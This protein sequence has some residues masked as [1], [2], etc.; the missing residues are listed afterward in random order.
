M[1]F[2]KYKFE[3]IRNAA[4]LTVIAAFSI[5]VYMQTGVVV[6]WKLQFIVTIY[7]KYE[8]HDESTQVHV[9]EWHFSALYDSPFT[10]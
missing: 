6:V 4:Q 7:K 5:T 3:A 1:S 9:L 8:H 10:S 2:C